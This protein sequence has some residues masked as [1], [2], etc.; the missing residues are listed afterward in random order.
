MGHP[1]QLRITIHDSWWGMTGAPANDRSTCIPQGLKPN[2]N[3]M[4]LI[5]PAKAVPLLQSRAIEFL[6]NLLS[7]TFFGAAGGTTE[8]VP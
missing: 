7:P 8:V 5:G 1:P 3:S 4:S 2:I 6:R